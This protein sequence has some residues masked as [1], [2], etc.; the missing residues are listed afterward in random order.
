VWDIVFVKHPDILEVVDLSQ[1]STCND[2]SR[3][4]SIKKSI[5]VE[6]YGQNYCTQIHTS[7]RLLLELAQEELNHIFEAILVKI[8]DTEQT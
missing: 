1:V 2:C 4:F 8:G 3:G 6:G 5:D 7:E